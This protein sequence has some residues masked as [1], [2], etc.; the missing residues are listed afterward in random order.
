MEKKLKIGFIGQG[1]VGKNYADNFQGRGYDVVR[2]DISPAYVS[3]REKI[4]DC[5]I[6]LIAVPTPTLPGKGFDDSIL[7]DVLKIVG[8]GKCAVIKSTM[9]IGTTEKLQ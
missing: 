7:V 5:D 4:K 3:N 9:K 1:Y 6:V 8:D 2:Y